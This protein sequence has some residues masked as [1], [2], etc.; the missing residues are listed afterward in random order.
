MDIEDNKMVSEGS[1]F[2]VHYYNEKN[3]WIINS[4]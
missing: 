2:S 1:T 4:Y 3:Q